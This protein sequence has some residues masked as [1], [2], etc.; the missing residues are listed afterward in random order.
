M[1]AALASLLLLAGGCS[2]FVDLSGLSG[3]GVARDDGAAGNGGAPASGGSGGSGGA[4]DDPRDAGPADGVPADAPDAGPA[5]SDCPRG[6]GPDMI[7]A[8]G[9]CIDGTEVTTSQYKAFLDERA[10]NTAGQG[11]PCT[12][13][14]SYAPDGFSPTWPPPGRE[15]HPVA[16]VDWCDARAFCAWAGKQ[17]CGRIGDGT[18]AP[19][20]VGDSQQSQ[21][22]SACSRAGSRGFPYG[23]ALDANACA[24]ARPERPDQLAEVGTQPSCQGGYDGLYDMGANVEEWVD[25]CDGA[26]GPGDQC[27]IAGGSVASRPSELACATS[28]YTEMRN[29]RYS[30]RGFRCCAR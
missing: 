24:V 11:A 28:H 10:G 22:A 12:W 25:A 21:W 29:D 13:N 15:R 5:P 3:G 23:P 16:S 30:L 4:P 7:R 26:S 6:R 2:Q 20:R 27:A 8:N 9:F 14:D 19:S 18:L 1:R 17:L